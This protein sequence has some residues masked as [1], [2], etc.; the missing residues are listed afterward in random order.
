MQKFVQVEKDL[1]ADSEDPDLTGKLP[2]NLLKTA[3]EEISRESLGIAEMQ[4]LMLLA[5]S[6][7]DSAYPYLGKQRVANQV[8]LLNEH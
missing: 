3:M 5:E 7:P 2:T 6:H 4:T 1:R 8:L